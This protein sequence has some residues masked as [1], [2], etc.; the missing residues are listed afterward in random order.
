MIFIKNTLV[1]IAVAFGVITI[2]AGSNV[3]LG[4]DPGYIVYRP[5]LIFNAGMGVLYVLAGITALR[6][7]RFGVVAAAVIFIVNLTV[8]STIYYL[9]TKGSPIAV[10]SLRAMTLRT[11]VWLGLFVG[12]GWLNYTQ[13]KL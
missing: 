3:L 4:S 10:D 9:Y 2:Y 8:L 11:V 12:F 6:N 7:L 1:L 5:L 13:K